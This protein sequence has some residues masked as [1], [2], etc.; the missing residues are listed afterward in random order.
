MEFICNFRV[1]MLD[2]SP[3]V[4]D[5]TRGRQTGS[6]SKREEVNREDIK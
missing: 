2:V 3:A 4:F 5:G 6:D 1:K